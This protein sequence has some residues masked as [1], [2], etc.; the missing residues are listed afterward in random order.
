M[1]E[2]MW[3]VLLVM[4]V[5]WLA[6]A[7]L[8]LRVDPGDVATAAGVVLLVAAVSEVLRALAGARTWWLAAGLAVLFAAAG[9][10]VWVGVDSSYASTAAVVGGFLMVRGVADV[11]V[12]ALLRETDRIW[13]FLLLLGVAEAALGVWTAAPA[14]RG[15]ETLIVVLAGLAVARAAAD[16]VG[17]LQ[18]WEGPPASLLDLPPERAAG[19][20]GYSAGLTDFPDGVA[21][22]RSQGLAALSAP[23]GSGPG[24][25]GLELAEP[26][27]AGP[28]WGSAAGSDSGG[29][30]PAGWG[31]AG[32]GAAGSGASGRAS[33]PPGTAGGAA[34]GAGA[35]PVG[36][37]Q[38]GMGAVG[39]RQPGQVGGQPGA[40]VGG[41]GGGWPGGDQS[42]SFHDEVLR[43]TADLDTML[44]MAG[45]TGTVTGAAA[46][47]QHV[48]LPP[49]PDTPEGVLALPPAEPSAGPW[50]PGTPQWPSG[51]PMPD[52][53]GPARP[54]ESASQR[55]AEAAP[56]TA[57]QRPPD[58]AWPP[59]SPGVQSGGVAPSVGYDPAGR[60][61]AAQPPPAQAWAG[62]SSD[63]TAGV[64]PDGT[65]DP[66]AAGTG[67]AAPRAGHRR[68][69]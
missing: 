26:G 61:P 44:A 27:S 45:V 25:V 58:P 11:T 3:A 9:V 68:A 67:D 30:G 55:P 46:A 35:G 60:Y 29:P 69:E 36:A 65:P 32:Q 39:G 52:G 54:E 18:L 5:A 34:G 2:R 24:L 63:G 59:A 37:G 40:G 49:V 12:A 19:V 64:V 42:S 66:Q 56:E 47:A 33:V 38:Q 23:G 28:G 51:A 10:L 57:W 43:T 22:Y 20:A 6:V 21:R 8:V 1:R 15:D 50:T 31:S 62:Q 7:W 13:G 41:Q 4:G 17:A 14:V 16:L 53:S 48:D